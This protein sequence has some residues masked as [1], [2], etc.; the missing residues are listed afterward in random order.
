MPLTFSQDFRST[1]LFQISV[2]I[3]YRKLRI[4]FSKLDPKMTCAQFQKEGKK[5]GKE[6]KEQKEAK[7]TTSERDEKERK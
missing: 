3:F 6:E 4:P 7:R 1:P 5:R 2:N